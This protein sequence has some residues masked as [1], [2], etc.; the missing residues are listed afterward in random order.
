[1]AESVLEFFDRRKKEQAAFKREETIRENVR[2]GTARLAEL[3]KSGTA[4]K[5]QPKIFPGEPVDAL[6]LVDKPAPLVGEQKT[7]ETK[8]TRPIRK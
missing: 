3:L 6:E 1:M 5:D 4:L 7:Q 8:R 2:T